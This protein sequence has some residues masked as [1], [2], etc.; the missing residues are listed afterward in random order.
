MHKDLFFGRRADPCCRAPRGS[1]ATCCSAACSAPVSSPTPL[2]WRSGYPIISAPFSARGA[3][4]AGLCALF[5]ARLLETQG[6]EK[7]RAFSS[8]I[9]T[10][11]LLVADRASDRGLGLH[12]HFHR[13]AGA[14]LSRRAAKIRARRQPDPDHLSLSFVHHARHLAIRHVECARAFRGGC[15]PRRSCL[16]CS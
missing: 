11:L 5:Y 3:F 6:L 13:S 8:Q 15:L 2:S 12:A 9:F 16:I 14:R 10:L 4:N 7:A 1:S